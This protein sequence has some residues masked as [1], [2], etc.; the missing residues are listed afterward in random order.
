[1]PKNA[2][3]IDNILFYFENESQ[4]YR[5]GTDMVGKVIHIL[6]GILARTEMS[7]GC[8]LTQTLRRINE[9]MLPDFSLSLSLSSTPIIVLLS[10]SVWGK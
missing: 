10:F 8:R 9:S 3:G 1:M 5:A 6:S 7:F 4:S 2:D